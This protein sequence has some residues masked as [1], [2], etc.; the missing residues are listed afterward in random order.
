M[1][2]DIAVRSAIPAEISHDPQL[3]ALYGIAHTAVTSKLVKINRVSEALWIC[4]LALPL[5]IDPAYALTAFHIIEGK[6]T[7]SAHLML[8]LMK[9][10]GYRCFDHSVPGEYGAIEVHEPVPGT[11]EFIL[12]GTAKFTKDDA[13]AAGLLSKSNWTKDIDSMLWSRTVARAARRYAPQVLM[14]VVYTP[15]E[16]GEAATVE[17]EV[18]PYTATIPAAPVIDTEPVTYDAGPA[19]EEADPEV[20]DMAP[21]AA[22]AVPQN[23]WTVESIKPSATDKEYWNVFL[24]NVEKAEKK[25]FWTANYVVANAL[26]KAVAL[27]QM[28]EIF[29]HDKEKRNI[30]EVKIA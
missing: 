26:D 10:A 5:G 18:Q 6:P 1:A 21:Q 13:R 11:G 24:I 25:K 2:N 16:M 7:M 20:I 15:D 27:G 30:I 9:R 17:Y 28:V 12:L 29:V 22:P 23:L 3:V 4:R 8:A 14:G 19:E